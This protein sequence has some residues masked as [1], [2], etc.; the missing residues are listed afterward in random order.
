VGGPEPRPAD[1]EGAPRPIDD[2][3]LPRPPPVHGKLPRGLLK[4]LERGE[5]IIFM[6]IAVSLLVIALVVFAEG[7]HALVVGSPDEQFAV[8]ITRAVNSALFNVVVLELVRTIIARLDH[9]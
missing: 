9:A 4:A 6:A 2:E 3:G 1:D 7:V 5:S 8:T